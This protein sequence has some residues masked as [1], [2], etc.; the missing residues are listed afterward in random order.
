MKNLLFIFIALITSNIHSQTEVLTLVGKKERVQTAQTGM[1]DYAEY[2]NRDVHVKIDTIAAYGRNGNEI[3]IKKNGV[4]I[5]TFYVSNAKQEEVAGKIDYYSNEQAHSL[6]MNYCSEQFAAM[7]R[8]IET[9]NIVK[10]PALAGNTTI[11]NVYPTEK[12]EKIESAPAEDVFGQGS[13]PNPNYDNADFNQSVGN[14]YSQEEEE[15]ISNSFIQNEKFDI[16][17]AQNEKII[18]QNR[19]GLW[20]QGGIAITQE[21]LDYYHH[22]RL[23]KKI[24]ANQNLGIRTPRY[25]R[26]KTPA[27]S[28]A[29]NTVSQPTTVGGG[30]YHNGSTDN[31]RL[32][33][34][35]ISG[36]RSMNMRNNTRS[37]SSLSMGSRSNARNFNT[38]TTQG[39]KRGMQR[40]NYRGS[41]RTQG[42]VRQQQSRGNAATSRTRNIR[43]SSVGMNRTR[44]NNRGNSASFRGNSSSKNF[45]QSRG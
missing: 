34:N 8:A 37:S 10:K 44:S 7:R 33:N 9:C 3:A 21:L 15:Q 38:S 11:I 4:I 28:S 45:R 36:S 22:R 40:T 6:I 2:H 41:Q 20:L 29:N 19:T 16:I 12:V 32:A 26:A 31:G 27:S 35:Q 24:K 42:N 13:I 23:V 18:R 17:I 25:H 5:E 14:S 1:N 39:S 43:T 30:G